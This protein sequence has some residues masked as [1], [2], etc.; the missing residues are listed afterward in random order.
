MHKRYETESVDFKTIGEFG[1][2]PEFDFKPQTAEALMQ[3]LGLLYLSDI[4]LGNLGLVGGKRSYALFGDLSRLEQALT[5]WTLKTLINDYNFTPVIVP[6]LLFSDIIKSCGFS[7]F[8]DR[9]Q[10]YSLKGDQRVCLVGTAEMPLA[11][12]NIGK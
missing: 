10:V 8:G 6:Q 4:K 1:T 12:L 3:K 2:K 9:S 11:A 7:P 5:R